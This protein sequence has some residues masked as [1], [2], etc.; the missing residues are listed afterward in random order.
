MSKQKILRPQKG[1]QE[2]FMNIPPEVPL[3][4]YGGAAGGGKSFALLMYILRFVDDPLWYGVCFRKTLKQL[5]RSLWKEAKAMYRPL[6]IYQ[7]GPNK[8][9][10]KGKA[11][12]IDSQGNYKIT[13]PS[14][15]I[16]E[17]SY[18]TSEK[19]AVENW[20][21]AQLSAAF[22]DEFTHFDEGSFNYIRTR[23]RSDSKYPSF[24][25][26]SMN[27]DPVHF[28]KDKYLK[29]FIIQ[30]EDNPKYGVLDRA[31]NGRIRYYIFDRGEIHTSW[32]KEDLIERF[33]KTNPRA[34][35]AVSS[36]LKDNALMMANNPE[37]ADDLEANDP[38]NAAMLLDGNWEYSRDSNG[39]WDRGTIQTVKRK[40][41]PRSTKM[42]RGWDKANT[43]VSTS[44]S[45]YD[46]DFTASAKVAKCDRGDFYIFGDYIADPEGNQ[47]G[48]FREKSGKRNEMILEQSLLDG[49]ETSVILPLD[50]GAA[51][52]IEFSDHAKELQSHGLIVFK[53]PMPYNKSK[54]LRFEPFC[55]ASHNGYVYFVED[56][57][58]KKVLDYLYLELESFDGDKNNGFKDD[59]VDCIASAFNYVSRIRIDKPVALPTIQSNTLLH[60]HRRRVR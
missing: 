53:D 33:P 24:I 47:I 25:R 8:G 15:A 38:A 52:Q 17:F 16:V 41:V 36:S 57:F 26:C 54:I 48:R 32:A 55:A 13:F 60:A 6:L 10:Y 49:D 11:K 42:C 22:F 43:T 21:G 58:D 27:P 4:F 9:K 56:S 34:Y 46:P 59:V 51:G 28:V 1:P 5:S 23:M 2:Q 3:V 30:D 7:T 20:Q 37:Y 12:I 14:G 19:D 40:D 50:P 18:L 45:S 35:T 39:I 31:L 29:P 44:N